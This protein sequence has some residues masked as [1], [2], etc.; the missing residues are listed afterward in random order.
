MHVA[1]G[2]V[3]SMADSRA[4]RQRYGGKEEQQRDLSQNAQ[5]MQIQI[6]FCLK[7]PVQ[8]AWKK[9]TN[10]RILS[11][12]NGVKNETKRTA[13]FD[14]MEGALFRDS[15]VLSQL[16]SLFSAWRVSGILRSAPD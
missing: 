7:H 11:G 12:I 15:E 1:N 9:R 14:G 6:H 16:R 10:I 3:L 8:S 5:K 4:R 2:C 13:I